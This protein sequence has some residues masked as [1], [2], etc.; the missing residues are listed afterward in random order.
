MSIYHSLSFWNPPETCP[1]TFEPS[2]WCHPYKQTPKSNQPKNKGKDVFLDSMPFLVLWPDKNWKPSTQ[3]SSPGLRPLLQRVAESQRRDKNNSL[4][5]GHMLKVW[6]EFWISPYYVQISTSD[7][8][9]YL[10]NSL[11]FS[12]SEAANKVPRLCLEYRYVLYE[13]PALCMWKWFLPSII[14]AV[15]F[16][17]SHFQWYNQ[18][19][20]STLSCPFHGKGIPTGSLLRVMARRYYSL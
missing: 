9:C 3:K 10:G 18:R 5:S 8:F 14:K 1:V 6:C 12:Q 11:S 2:Q 20:T 4:L 15:P 16:L 19:H 7:F 17:C 13:D